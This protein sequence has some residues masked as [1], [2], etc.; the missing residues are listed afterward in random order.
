MIYKAYNLAREAHKDQK[1]LSGEDYVI[2][3][4]SVAYIL[5][6]MQMD[7]ETI[8][9]AILHDVIEDTIYSYDYIGKEFNQDIA[10]LVEGCNKNRSDWFSIQRRESG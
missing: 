2:H 5:A 3:P 9:A 10:D 4:V 6:E 7:T 1:R 8:V